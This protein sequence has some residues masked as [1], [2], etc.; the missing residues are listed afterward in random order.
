MRIISQL[1]PTFLSIHPSKMNM[2]SDLCSVLNG[3][4]LLFNCIAWP[5]T[6][7]PECVELYIA[8]PSPRL[9]LIVEYV[10]P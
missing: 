6:C 5:Y 8:I 7:A 4:G 1:A 2:P 9:S 3:W 10:V